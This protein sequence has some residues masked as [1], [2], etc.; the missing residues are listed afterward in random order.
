EAN[1]V[2][3]LIDECHDMAKKTHARLVTCS[4]FD[5]IPS[6]LGAWLAWDHA[7][8]VHGENLSWVKI[9][10]G[11]FKGG[12][13]GGTLASILGIIDAA[14]QSRDLR[15]LLLDPHGLDPQRGHAPRDPFEDDQRGVRFDKDLR[16]WT[17]P[18]VMAAINA[19]IVRRSHALL[20]EED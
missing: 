12:T 14:Q 5:S 4:G 11:R 16:R 2:R 1:F 9:F 7:K 20:R 6:D 17:A 15:R 10:T 8:R 13:S 3:T 18:F 19:R